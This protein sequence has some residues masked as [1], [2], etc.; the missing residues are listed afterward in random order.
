MGQKMWLFGGFGSPIVKHGLAI[1]CD[2]PKHDRLTT[3]SVS[4]GLRQRCAILSEVEMP[5]KRDSGKQLKNRNPIELA[6]L[7]LNRTIFPPLPEQESLQPIARQHFDTSEVMLATSLYFE[8]AFRYRA[9][10]RILSILSGSFRRTLR[11]PC[12]TTVRLW[13]LRLGLYKLRS[14][15][16]GPRW[17]MICDH[18][19]T[20][21][22]LK[23]FVICGVDLDRLDHRVETGSGN[24][25][26]SHHDVQP[27]ALV[28]MKNSNGEV[29]LEHHLECIAKHGNPES[30]ITD[31]GSD[32]MKSARLLGE[33]QRRG[34]QLVTRHTYDVSHRIARIIQ[35]Q[36]EA[37][38]RWQ[39]FEKFVRDARRY[40]KYK[41]K[42]LSPPSLRHGPDRW[43][44]LGGVLKWYSK[45]VERLEC[46]GSTPVT[47]RFGLTE[48]VWE[49]GRATYRKCG[50]LFKSLKRLCGKE[51]AD[52]KAYRE[53][54]AERCPEMPEG[55]KG[56]LD[57]RKDLNQ[58]HLEEVMEGW[59]EHQE[60]HRE[61]SGLL[62]FTNGIQK[63]L[64]ESGL[65]KETVEEC[66]ETCQEACLT[67]SGETI[68][69]KVMQT[70]EA[71][72]EGLTEGERLL[73]TSDVVESLNG[74]WK[75]LIG[76][77]RT[78]ALAGNALLMAALM[79]EPRSGAVKQALEDVK[80]RD[81][82]AWTKDTFGIT[83][84]QEKSPKSNNNLPDNLQEFA[85]VF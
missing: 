14:A 26:L 83:F 16:V 17:A 80:V 5:G 10:G 42:G 9:A 41:A 60:I 38:E 71:M 69:Q 4:G 28:P 77:S 49:A 40:C 3:T 72:A 54:L 81:V 51:H 19:A 23:L 44:N 11:A 61:V 1:V 37:S 53:A 35:G 12:H 13:A 39:N 32:I 45:M 57:E 56:Y 62:E 36:L 74:K 21:G 20:F 68:G 33:H 65:S 24:F 50:K 66:R 18:T 59:E 75:M 52:E 48:A 6:S 58:A 64:K 27:L 22:G 25:S 55:M 63:R 79:G 76:G 82:E 8:G 67:G 70:V 84:H 7:T 30:M 78:P 2:D 15:R 85:N 47:P 73:A 34:G 43:M 46:Q 31:G 29:L